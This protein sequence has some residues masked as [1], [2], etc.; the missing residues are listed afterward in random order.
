MNLLVSEDDVKEVTRLRGYKFLCH[1]RRKKA[2]IELISKTSPVGSTILDVGCASG[3]IALELSLHGYS[4]HGIDFE[5]DK[6]F[7]AKDLANKYKKKILFENKS[8]EELDSQTSYDSVLLGEVLEHFIDPA[9]ILK[10]ISNLLKPNGRIFISTPNMPSLRNRLKFGLFGVFPDNNAEHKY[11]FD[12]TR[13]SKVIAEA[14]YELIS[15]KTCFTNLTAKSKS[16][17]MIENILLFWFPCLFKR[18]GDTIFAVISPN[19]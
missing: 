1:Q 6:V 13:I 18:S 12:Y 7:R 9:N 14:G 2:I 16:L 8:F 5:S 4:V 17:A 19:S 3:D 15:F 10:D 11:Y